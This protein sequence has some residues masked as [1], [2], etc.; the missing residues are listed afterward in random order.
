MAISPSSGSL[1][2]PGPS[3][4]L[5]TRYP[6][7]V[8]LAPIHSLNLIHS[9]NKGDSAA[10]RA[11]SDAG[12]P[13]VLSEKSIMDTYTYEGENSSCTAFEDIANLSGDRVKWFQLSLY[14]RMCHFSSLIFTTRLLD[15]AHGI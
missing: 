4:I 11:A 8:I 14:V 1:T 10:A 12:I 7:P 6:S 3:G 13:Y 2:A 15:T 5:G 9:E